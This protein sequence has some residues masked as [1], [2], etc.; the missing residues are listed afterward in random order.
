MAIPAF[1]DQ[2]P[3]GDHVTTYDERHLVTYL[4]LLDANADKA[5]WKEAVSIIFE[6]D[7]VVDPARAKRI[8]DSHLARALW[9]TR[10]GYR[11]LLAKP[12]GQSPFR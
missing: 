1:E 4:R 8:H 3:T 9:M 10:T 5:D 7:V 6:L 2:P 12:R 11:D